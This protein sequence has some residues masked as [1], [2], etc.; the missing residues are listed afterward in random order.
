MEAGG[1]TFYSLTELVQVVHWTSLAQF[2]LVLGAL[3]SCCCGKG[4][5]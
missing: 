2:D 3:H 5:F 4:L 1:F